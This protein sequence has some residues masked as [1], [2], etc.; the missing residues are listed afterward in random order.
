MK[1][2]LREQDAGAKGVL[3]EVQEDSYVRERFHPRPGD[4]FYLHLSDLL[5][6]MKLLAT[7]EKIRLL[8]F[9]CGGSPY[10]PLFPNAEYYRA[11]LKSIRE[12]DFQI[13]D[14]GLVN[15]PSDFFDRVLST[16]VLEHCPDP[17]VYLGECRRVLKAA[18]RLILSTHGLFEEHDCPGDYYRWTEDGLRVALHEHQ[19]APVSV[20]RV[21][22]G[23]RAGLM[24][25]QRTV[26]PNHF[27]EKVALVRAIWWTVRRFLLARRRFWD[28][29]MDR[30]FSQYRFT[31]GTR[32]PGDNI[33]IALLAVAKA[34]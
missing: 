23:P 1:T 30:V 32:M 15:A 16:Q 12:V 28:P 27:H 7:D 20:T 26:V 24:L 8:D 2:E 19:L 6:A 33:Y 5:L 29:I 11:D 34:V 31:S 9:G 13:N 3:S 22:I 4:A 14:Q 18:G 21:T 17:S 25:L 10:R